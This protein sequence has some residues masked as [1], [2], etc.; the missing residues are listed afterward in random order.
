[1]DYARDPVGTLAS[2]AAVG[3]LVGTGLALVLGRRGD[4]AAFLI[5]ACT[6]AGGSLGLVLLLVDVLL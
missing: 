2:F 6:V 4:S 3:A 1:V 5:G